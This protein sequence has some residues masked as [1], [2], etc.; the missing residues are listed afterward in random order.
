M[1]TKTRAAVLKN[2]KGD[3]VF[4]DVFIDDPS[5][6]EILV[7]MVACGICHT[8]IAIQDGLVE[9]RF[10]CILG[11]EGAGIVE[12]LGKKVSRFKPGDKVLLSFTSCGR[13][14]NCQKDH[15]AYC[16]HFEEMNFGWGRL[17]GSSMIHD[18]KKIPLGGNFFGQSSFSYFALAQERNAIATDMN[19]E[20]LAT[21]APLG[22]GIQAG[23]GTVLHELKPKPKESLA[24]FGVGSVGL[25]A[26]MAARLAKADPIIAIDQVQSRLTLAKE[27]GAHFVIN[28]E[29]EQIEVSLKKII[30]TVD[31]IVETT[32]NS[33]IID[34]A[35]K[36]LSLHGKLS[37]LGISSNNSDLPKKS[38]Q[39][40]IASIAGDSNP[41]EFIPFLIDLHKKGKFPFD[42]LLR[43]YAAEDINQ[44]IKDSEAG[45]AIKPVLLFN[46]G[47]L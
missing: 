7:Q 2:P 9:M 16:S 40:I 21:Y 5:E 23:A 46:R 20:Q 31:C 32:G 33:Q 28:T 24:V 15:P 30:G 17:D 10:P 45:I 26:V 3:F 19:E 22:C 34:Q 11:H 39:T 41:Q 35:L 27:L 38:G 12:K 25:A 14:R 4:K 37:L 6:H 36:S 29:K 44:A 13:C 42:R 47:S 8:D 18:A 43:Y 1:V